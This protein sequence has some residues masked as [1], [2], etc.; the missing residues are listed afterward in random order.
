MVKVE[1]IGNMDNTLD[2]TFESANRVYSKEG[3]CPT[4][5]TCTG[6]GIQPKVIEETK[7][8]GGLS[9]KK[10]GDKQFHQQDRVYKGDIALAHPANLPEGSYKYIVAMRGRGDKNEQR[11]EPN[12][13]GCTN[14]L[15]TVQK[16]NLILENKIKKVGQISNEGSQCG[17]VVSEDGLYPTI[18]AGCHGYANPHILAKEKVVLIKQATKDGSIPCKEGGC[19]DGSFPDSTTRRGRV[20]ENG[21]VVPTLTASNSDQINYV[22]TVYR[23]RKLTPRECFRLMSFCDEDFNAAAYKKEILYLEGDKEKCNANLKVVPEKQKLVN[24]ETY[25]LCTINDSVDME[26]LKTIKRLLTEEQSKENLQSVDFVITRSVKMEHLECATSITR[27]ITFMG[28]HFILMEEKDRH[29]MVIIVQEEEDKQNTEKCMKITMELNSNPL[30][31]YIILILFVQIMKLGI[32]GSTTLQVN[33]NGNIQIIDDCENSI[34]LKISFLK[35]EN[36]ST[37]VSSSQLYKQA[38]NSICE[39]VLKAIFR[40]MNIKGVKTWDEVNNA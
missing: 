8:V 33:I 28:I 13:S 27:C 10:W 23:I 31:L 7:C 17:T 9:D 40:N 20:Q 2:N 35:M 37:R 26:I 16:D 22:E 19:F 5:P 14:I 11:L 34:L 21:D 12:T 18:S 36:I 1:I 24:T 15:T 25:V 6:G 38:G 30:K 39:C 29:Q 32:Y 3:L 4:I